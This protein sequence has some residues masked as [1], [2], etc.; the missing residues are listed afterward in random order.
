MFRAGVR[1]R[2]PA[3]RLS[4][5]C[6]TLAAAGRSCSTLL[7]MS[8]TTARLF[9]LLLPLVVC[10]AA[11]AA[12]D[13]RTTLPAETSAHAAERHKLVAKRRADVA[14]ICHRGSWEFA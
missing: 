1:R 14:V 12:T 2:T 8:T 3:L 11:Q 7:L 13:S 9:S 4:A 5:T 6:R 10:C